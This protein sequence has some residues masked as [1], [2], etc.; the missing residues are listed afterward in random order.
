MTKYDS[1]DQSHDTISNAPIS[2]LD[3]CLIPLSGIPADFAHQYGSRQELSDLRVTGAILL[4]TSALSAITSTAGLHLVMGDGAFHPSYAAAGL[5]IGGLTGAIDFM[6]QYKGTLNSRGLAEL[7]RGGLKLPDA[8]STTRIPFFVRLVRVGQAAVFGFLGG[9][10]LIIG[11][12][13]SDVHSYIDGKFMG[14]NPTVAADAAKLAD[15]GIARAKQALS[16]EEGEVNNLSRSIQA[17]R[18]NDTR[19]SIGRKSNAPPTTSDPKLDVLR[20]QLAEAVAKRDSLAKNVSEQ[21]SGRNGF[22]EKTIDE[23][24][25]AIRKRTGL[26]A[27]L[28]ALSALTSENPKLLLF[29]LAFEFLSLALELGPMWAAATRIPSALA[30][31]LSLE[32]FI[33]VST[34]SKEGAEK[35]GA[36]VIDDQ[37]TPAPIEADTDIDIDIPPFDALLP[38]EANDN[39]PS[40]PDALHG[41]QKRGAGRPL[42]SKNRPKPINGAGHE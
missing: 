36:R 8:E 38:Q 32:H 10:F 1:S 23:N 14:A 31:R 17:M 25:T 11:A 13:F 37:P 5:F 19:R 35:L 12:N 34:L 29:I 22:I 40:A 24:P 4:G 7:R 2:A 41:V 28:E 39:T 30:A 26:A 21:E 3:R 33:R 27:Q 6:C 18:S 20:G 15:T 16:V 42:G 9:T